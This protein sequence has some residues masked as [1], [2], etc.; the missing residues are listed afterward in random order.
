MHT[1]ADGEPAVDLPV[2]TIRARRLV[3]AA[4]TFG[5]TYLLLRNRLALPGLS[6][7]LGT[8]FSGNGDLLGLVMDSS[9]DGVARGPRRQHRPG[10]HHRDPGRR[11]G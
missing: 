3:L 7:A 2:R 8:R 11:R 9:R 1:G 4:G 6:G 5:T 10:H